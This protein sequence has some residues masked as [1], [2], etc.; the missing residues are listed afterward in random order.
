MGGGAGEI[1]TESAK[2]IQICATSMYTDRRQT[3]PAAPGITRPL[4]T[5]A[6]SPAVP[7]SLSPS[8]PDP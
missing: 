5:E 6:H 7:Q 1:S 3:S 8:V 2:E 4:R